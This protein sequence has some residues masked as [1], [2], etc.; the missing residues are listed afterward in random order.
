MKILK[1]IL[2]VLFFP[3]ALFIALRVYLSKIPTVTTVDKI[4]ETLTI[5]GQTIPILEFLK[6]APIV[7]GWHRVN[8]GRYWVAVPVDADKM[9]YSYINFMGFPLRTTWPFK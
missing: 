7:D 5:D 9:P 8:R 6:D 4:D 3:T 2:V 1:T